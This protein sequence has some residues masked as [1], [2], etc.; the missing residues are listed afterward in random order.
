[1]CPSRIFYFRTHS[2]VTILTTILAAWLSSANASPLRSAMAE[3]TIQTGIQGQQETGPFSRIG[4]EMGLS[5][6][7]VLSI[8]QD[9]EGCMWFA[10]PNGLNRF[11]GYEVSV[12]NSS[13]SILP[14]NITRLATDGAGNILIC[15]DKGLYKY[16][17][18]K[19]NAVAVEMT[20]GKE[21]TN[22]IGIDGE[23]ILLSTQSEI[24]M[25]TGKDQNKLF[26]DR[27]AR[28]FCQDGE[29]L[30]IGDNHGEISYMTRGG[31]KQTVRCPFN[32][33]INC[34]AKDA[35]DW[36][37]AGSEGDG[38]WHVNI[39]SGETVRVDGT[40]SA[41][42]RS[43]SKDLN[44]RLWIGTIAG[45]NIMDIST[46]RMTTVLND[47]FDDGSLP[48]NSIRSL[49][50]DSS[51]GM[52]LGTWY[53][54]AAYYHPER[55]R[56]NVIRQS[57]GRNSLND[58][59][60]SRIVQDPDG[61]VWVGTNKGGLNH[62]DPASG[63]WRNIKFSADNGTDTPESDN[64]KA[65]WCHPDGKRLYVGTHAGALHIVDKT[66]GRVTS[67]PE[68]RNVY[69][70]IPAGEDHL[71]IGTLGT[72]YLYDL[73][74]NSYSK[75]E[76]LHNISILSLHIDD[77]GDLWIGTKDRVRVFSVDKDFNL[78]PVAQGT[79]AGIAY[80]QCFHERSDMTI[81]IGTRT[82]LYSIDRKDR[83]MH[84]YDRS[85]GMPDNWVFGIEEDNAGRL[86]ASTGKGLWCFDPAT[87]SGKTYTVRDGL[88]SDKFTEYAH[89]RMQDG[90]MYFG[91]IG[92]IVTFR[93]DRIKTNIATPAPII[94]GLYVDGERI[95]PRERDGVIVLNH[96]Q[97]SF[98]IR[99]SIPDYI[100]GGQDSFS[101]TLSGLEKAWHNTE[102]HEAAFTHIR[103][104]RYTFHLKAA[105]RD[106]YW[107]PIIRNL[108][109][110]IVPP[111][112]R[113]T[114]ARI[115]LL[116]LI[117]GTTAAL[118]IM[119]IRQKEL[120]NKLELEQIK[121]RHKEEIGK[122]RALAFI[123]SDVRGDNTGVHKASIS[124]TD[125]SLLLRAMEVV[126]QNLGN[127]N[128]GVEDFAAALGMSRSNLHLRLKE[129]TG[130][131]ALN[132]IHKVRFTKACTLLAEG[133]LN[134]SEI[135]EKCGFKSPSYFTVSF[136]KYMGC[137]PSEYTSKE[138]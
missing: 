59:I 36:F 99:F 47:P 72:L 49:F 104:G 60:I 5:N 65:I 124:K 98:T 48:D 75:S 138:S 105:N 51:G 15:T 67:I 90:E 27:R 26:R 64:V 83:T 20:A 8:C 97:N 112:Y 122:F 116:L 129:I 40:S 31:K 85:S 55:A 110:R 74:N 41:Y 101:Y 29:R 58:N 38:L 54:G 113:T 84:H 123:N 121:R 14:D 32:S 76:G 56:F 69:S 30:V 18:A 136:R 44:G 4:M 109:I 7:T 78:T 86:W 111:W 108:S 93:P 70:I 128:F 87:E 12:F 81:W 57:P 118:V 13:N 1:M 91:G 95:M 42:I 35:G 127:E 45:L 53:G 62:Y 77:S 34:I 126:E 33:W 96:K 82:G 137:S 92:G 73:R 66:S 22:A 19:E 63:E 114:L 94:S 89:C 106:G 23:R 17:I 103:K 37:W 11:D 61:S 9:G 50:F 52:W 10:T 102:A 100:S 16:D 88:P 120:R 133:K 134:I 107:S 119:Q 71:W 43:M 68:I 2:F 24:I 117:I 80:A 132:M 28:A 79:E 6:C 3:N 115:V 25:L 135:S 125:E 131:S 39:S 46:G 130:E 21:I